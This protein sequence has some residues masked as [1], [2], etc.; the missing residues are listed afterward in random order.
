MHNANFDSTVSFEEARDAVESA[1]SVDEV[2]AALGAYADE[3][4]E[5]AP[6][7]FPPELRS[8]DGVTSLAVELTRLGMRNGLD[9]DREWRDLETLFA[10]AAVRISE[11]LHPS[12]AVVPGPVANP[13]GS[14][15]GRP[16][17]R[18]WQRRAAR[19]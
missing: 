10:R 5:L 17:D 14:A 15:R 7:V 16:A 13:A 9:E 8:R 6:K 3:S 12:A 19:G 4:G 2:V 18:P 1:C 11:L